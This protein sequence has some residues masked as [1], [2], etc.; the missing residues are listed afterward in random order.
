MKSLSFSLMIEEPTTIRLGPNI[1]NRTDTHTH[2]PGN[3]LWGALASRYLTRNDGPD[4]TFQ[5]I[6]DR[7]QRFRA[8]FPVCSNNKRAFQSSGTELV[9]K[10]DPTHPTIDRFSLFPGDALDELF[11]ETGVGGFAAAVREIQFASNRHGCQAP[12]QESP[13]KTCGGRLQ[14]RQIFVDERA[15]AID[16]SI[17]LRNRVELFENLAVDGQLFS[18]SYLDPGSVFAGTILVEDDLVEPFRERCQFETGA[19]LHIGAAR[20]TGGVATLTVGQTV[21]TP[22]L[23]T[24]VGIYVKVLNIET[25]TIALDNFL[26]PTR[27][28]Q[29]PGYEVIDA[30]SSVSFTTVLGFNSAHAM[31]RTTD[32]A[33]AP[34]SFLV[35]ASENPTDENDQSILQNGLGLR[36]NEGWGEVRLIPRPAGKPLETAA[37]SETKLDAETENANAQPT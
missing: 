5:K 19:V 28:P 22:A 36:R 33:I 31:P 29:V 21:D 12:D 8:A 6:F 3:V 13:T 15:I 17:G 25:P 34:G 7:G 18:L 32:I 23:P 1:G 26:R 2:V 9:C 16:A 27:T 24:D 35:V 4:A 11:L 10:N 30:L 14:P 20:S 37:D